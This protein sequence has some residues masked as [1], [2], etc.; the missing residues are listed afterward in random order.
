[1]IPVVPTKQTKLSTP[2]PL[3]RPLFQPYLSRDCERDTHV[4]EAASPV[5]PRHRTLPGPP[6]TMGQ[7]EPRALGSPSSPPPGGPCCLASPSFASAWALMAQTK[8]PFNFDSCEDLL[9]V[10]EPKHMRN[11]SLVF[12][13]MPLNNQPFLSKGC[14]IRTSGHLNSF[15]KMSPRQA[16][17]HSANLAIHSLSI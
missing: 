4:R 9:Q 14:S 2:K 16:A 11:A 12:S 3:P 8:S 17:K 10:S 7:T 1:M 15:E 6:P 13:M 5:G